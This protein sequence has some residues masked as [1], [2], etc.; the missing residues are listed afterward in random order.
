[1]DAIWKIVITFDGQFFYELSNEYMYVRIPWDAR[2]L[3]LWK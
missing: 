2:P 3:G 1:M